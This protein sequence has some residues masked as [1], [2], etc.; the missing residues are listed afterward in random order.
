MSEFGGGSSFGSA[1]FGG[2]PTPFLW[3]RVDVEMT[4]EG[5]RLTARG[6]TDGT[7]LQVISFSVGRGGFDPNDYLAALPVNPDASALSDSIFTDQVDHIEW[8]NQQCVV[9]YCALDSAE[10]NQTLGEIAITGRVANSPGDPADDATIVMAIGHFPMLA[11][12][13]DMRYVLRVTLQA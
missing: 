8:A 1:V 10:A 7:S 4:T 13:S 3:L 6:H 12:N 2:E 11:K 5:R 9:C